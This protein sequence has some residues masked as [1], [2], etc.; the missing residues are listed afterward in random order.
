MI[1]CYKYYHLSPN[2]IPSGYYRWYGPVLKDTKSRYKYLLKPS[3]LSIRLR[4]E[5]AT[6]QK[7]EYPIRQGNL[8]GVNLRKDTGTM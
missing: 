3:N 2:S 7:V 5:R 4:G 1:G 8:S 6:L